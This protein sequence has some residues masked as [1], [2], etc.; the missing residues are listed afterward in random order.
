M[1]CQR[2]KPPV[3]N[4]E[5]QKSERKECSENLSIIPVNSLEGLDELILNSAIK[6]YRVAF[7]EKPYFENFTHEE[8]LLSFK[9]ILDRGGPLLFGVLNNKTL[10]IA[11][12]YKRSDETY[13]IE[14]ILVHPKH[15]GKGYG[16]NIFRA[17]LDVTNHYQRHELM[18]TERDNHKALNF[19]KKCGFSPEKCAEIVSQIRL[20]GKISLDKRIYYSKSVL[21]VNENDTIPSQLKRVVITYPSGNAT[22]VVFDDLLQCDR[23]SLNAIVMQAWEKKGTNLSIEQ[24]CFVT[25]PKNTNAVARVE[26]FGGEFCANATRSVI[27]LLTKGEDYEGLIEVSGVTRP[28]EFQVKNQEITVEM[29]LPE[30]ENFVSIVDEGT[31]VHLEGITHL[32]VDSTQISLEDLK[33][34]PLIEDLVRQNKYSFNDLPAVGV[35]YFDQDTNRARFFVRVKA[36]DTVFDETACGSGTCAIGIALAN[37]NSSSIKL[38]VIQPTGE[39]I[40]TIATESNGLIPKSEIAGKVSCIYDGELKLG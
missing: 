14:E 40:H 13:Y 19:Y 26:M 33:T 27:Q 4:I 12:G 28:L 6:T 16:I 2:V 11:G 37:K 23:K 30:D 32:V 25:F 20:D 21:P 8:V 38:D 15:Q 17:L 18:T 22:A 34:S 31:L 5:E 10:S 1:Y 35:C 36:V 7:S 24:C 29:P 9:G 3:A 39:T